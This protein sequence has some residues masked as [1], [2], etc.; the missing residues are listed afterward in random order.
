MSLKTA[1][2]SLLLIILTVVLGPG[3]PGT[4]RE[5][6]PPI[7]P[8]MDSTGHAGPPADTVRAFP[9]GEELLYEV[10]WWI[11]RLGTIRVRVVDTADG[12]GGM[13]T[14][15]R[16]DIDSYSGIPL[17]NLHVTTETVMDSGWRSDRFL[18]ITQDGDAW[19]TI[20]YRYAAGESLLF[21]ERGSAAGREA[22]DFEVTKVETVGVGPG[23][24]DG[25][26]ILYFARARAAN[27]GELAVA[28]V[29]EGAKGS[30]AFDFH[31]ERG[32]EEID[33]VDYP[34]DVIG[35]S[36]RADFSGI[37][38]LTGEFEGR[39]SN[40]DAH[41]P[42]RATLEVVLGSVSVELIGWKRGGW[43]PPRRPED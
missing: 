2:N 11:V 37:F 40:D 30:T 6:A 27:G 28:T 24:H 8:R 32:A 29:V 33:A 10:S 36:G 16:A 42:V 41:V 38:G 21:V 1:T 15:A 34:V 14:T 43:K 4:P 17:A 13:R 18:G 3:Q 9:P 31:G 12:G 20:R 19:R 22:R 23:Y 7:H 25:L 5:D 26:S 39:F 35:L